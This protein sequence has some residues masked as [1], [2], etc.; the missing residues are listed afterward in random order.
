MLYLHQVRGPISL[1]RTA[2]CQYNCCTPTPPSALTTPIPL[3]PSLLPTVSPCQP[4]KKRVL[5]NLEHNVE[6]NRKQLR[7]G[8]DQA[9]DAPPHPPPADVAVRFLDWTDYCASLSAPPPPATPVPQGNGLGS[10]TAGAATSSSSGGG[11]PAPASARSEN[12][13]GGSGGVP[14]DGRPVAD[15]CG[16]VLG[17]S[18]RPSPA[19]VGVETGEVERGPEDSLGM[20]EVVLAADVV[21]D[22][23][24]HPALVG[25]VVEALRRCPDALV[26]FASTVSERAIGDIHVGFPPPRNGRIRSWLHFPGQ[27]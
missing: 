22:V 27:T 8:W 13:G 25:V 18:R 4:R 19:A 24:Y 14:G 12:D 20:P 17:G 26:V 5:S 2:D 1:V 16:G 11:G 15:A 3:R 23:K 9:D 21:Y 10:E 7:N 6:I